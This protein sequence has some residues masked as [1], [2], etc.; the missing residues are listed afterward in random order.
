MLQP[1]RHIAGCRSHAS[2]TDRRA[3]TRHVHPLI[4]RETEK[5]GDL[6]ARPFW[7]RKQ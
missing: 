4:Q 6:L 2:S 5:C 1:L 3:V 7:N